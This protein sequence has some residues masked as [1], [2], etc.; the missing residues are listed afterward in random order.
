MPF[1]SF[2]ILLIIIVALEVDVLTESNLYGPFAVEEDI[3]TRLSDCQVLV[4]K[5]FLRTQEIYAGKE[6]LRAM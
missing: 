6:L 3:L 4:L 5:L 2:D 1:I